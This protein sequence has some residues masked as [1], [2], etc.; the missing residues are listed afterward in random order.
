MAD[1]DAAAWLDDQVEEVESVPCPIC[2]SADQEEVLLLCDGCDAPY[3]THCVGLDRVPNGHWFCMECET[4]RAIDPTPQHRLRRGRTCDE[5]T[6]AQLRVARRRAR[7]DDWQGAW[8]Q[9][10]SRVWEALNLDLDFMDDDQALTTFR[11]HQRRSA[12]ERR[13]FSQWQQRLDIAGRQGARQVFRD[14]A[15]PILSEAYPT[16]VDAPRESVDETKAWDAFEKAKELETVS[17]SSRKRKAR[18]N[19]ASPTE[20]TPTSEPER[21]QKR[22]RTRRVLEVAGSGVPGS[23]ASPPMIASSGEHPMPPAAAT[24]EQPSF[25][26]SLLKEVEMTTIPEEDGTRNRIT[27]FG[28]TSPSIE[29]SSPAAS[30]IPSNHPSPRTMSATPPPLHLT[31]RPGSP[32]PLTSHVQPAFATSDYSPSRQ[33]AEQTRLSKRPRATTPSKINTRVARQQGASSPTF[34]R[35]TES[36][37]VRANMSAEAKEGI[38]KVVRT[39]LEPFWRPNRITKEQYADINCLVSRMLYE[40]IPDLGTVNDRSK[41]AWDKLATAE[42]TKAVEGL[43][44]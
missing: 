38:S 34:Q 27:P 1:F 40:H 31:N 24:P 41:P 3:H 16:T 15:R 32:L 26:S 36:S 43:S 9:I 14:A 4:Q 33:Q 17:P 35:S 29:Y 39:A 19:T 11:G 10:S 13:E 5:R 6:Q 2:N 28:A 20:Q 7:T 30:P 18:S 21:K 25:L 12:R 22:P 8:S 44:G 23:S 42:V 37:P